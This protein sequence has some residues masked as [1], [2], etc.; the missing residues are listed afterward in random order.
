M[1]Q[2][3]WHGLERITGADVA[4]SSTTY[5]RFLNYARNSAQAESGRLHFSDIAPLVG[6]NPTVAAEA[7][8]RACSCS[9]ASQPGVFS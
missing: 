4:L 2:V 3:S 1:A 7:F 9:L 5:R 8:Y 6:S